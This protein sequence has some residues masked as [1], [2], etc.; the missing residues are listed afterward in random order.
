M[1]HELFIIIPIIVCHTTN[2]L[3]LWCTNQA[4]TEPTTICSLFIKP[5]KEPG[6]TNV[7]KIIVS[8]A[9]YYPE[10]KDVNS[11][12]RTTTKYCLAASNSQLPMKE[13][14][15]CFRIA[16][17]VIITTFFMDCR[18]KMYILLLW[19]LLPSFVRITP[20]KTRNHEVRIKFSQ[21]GKGSR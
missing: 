14:P 16:E 17:L 15:S 1:H 12:H 10:K 3:T 9:R 6:W 19:A 7:L 18:K 5:K 20:P 11:I 2:I 21:I 4:T 8:T 13:Q